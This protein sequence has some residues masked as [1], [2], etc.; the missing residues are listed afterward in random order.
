MEAPPECGYNHVFQ[1]QMPLGT[2]GID[3]PWVEWCSEHCT[4]RWG[5]YFE[6]TDQDFQMPAGY[7]PVF[8]EKQ[9][10]VMTFEEAQDLTTFA[11]F[12]NSSIV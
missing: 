12:Y 3:L 6:P 10:C 4:G 1:H 7:S 2:Y 5:W 8:Y 11:L 9:E